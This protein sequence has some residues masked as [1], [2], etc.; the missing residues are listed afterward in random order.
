MEDAKELLN[1]TKDA[2][3]KAFYVPVLDTLHAYHALECW[4][5]EPQADVPE[6][7]LQHTASIGAVGEH[8]LTLIQRLELEAASEKYNEA[9]LMEFLVLPTVNLPHSIRIHFWLSLIANSL[10]SALIT[11][12]T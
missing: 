8:L 7:S 9:Y 12:I 10:L 4:V 2:A 5:E 1:E 3:I 11:K 6:F